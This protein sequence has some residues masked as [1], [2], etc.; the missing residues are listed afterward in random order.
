VIDAERA[1]GA[2]KT[3]RPAYGEDKTQIIPVHLLL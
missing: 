3:T 2:R 1:R